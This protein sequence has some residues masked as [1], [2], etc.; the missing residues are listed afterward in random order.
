MGVCGTHSH[1]TQA[2]ILRLPNVSGCHDP[3]G[4][5]NEILPPEWSLDALANKLHVSVKG[6]G[7]LGNMCIGLQPARQVYTLDLNGDTYDDNEHLQGY[8]AICHR[9]M[10]PGRTHQSPNHE[11]PVLNPE[12]LACCRN[13]RGGPFNGTCSVCGW[14]GHKVVQCDHL[15]MFIFLSW[16]VKSID[17]DG[18]MAIKERWIDKNKKWLG[19]DAKPPLQG[20]GIISWHIR[21]HCQPGGS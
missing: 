16:Y 4:G 10:I 17:T 13:Q 14:F 5:D 19:S 21:P 6:S 12:R 2:M 11:H 9:A 7:I 18:V 20:G 15:A 3:S 1:L 8:L